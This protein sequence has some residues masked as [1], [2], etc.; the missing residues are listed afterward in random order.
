LRFL[1]LLIQN[2][3]RRFNRLGAWGA[4]EASEQPLVN[5][6]PAACSNDAWNS[7]V[8]LSDPSM[9]EKGSVKWSAQIAKQYMGQANNGG[10]N[11][12]LTYSYDLDA[13]DV[14]EALSVV[15]AH[16]AAAQLGYV[17]KELGCPLP[18]SSEQERWDVLARAWTDALDQADFLSIEADKELMSV[19]EAHVGREEDFYLGLRKNRSPE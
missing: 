14:L 1:S 4:S 7:F 19:L 18:A 6:K 9:Y 17:V 8:L 5:D 13:Q 15:E 2:L 12:Y 11:S 16:I 3:S 10:L